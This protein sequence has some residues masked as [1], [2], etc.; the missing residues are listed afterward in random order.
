MTIPSLL[1]EPR[2]CSHKDKEGK[3][4]SSDSLGGWI[5]T[6][7]SQSWSWHSAPTDTPLSA[8]PASRGVYGTVVANK[9][10]GEVFWGFLER[11]LI[12]N[13]R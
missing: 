5:L 9:R 2:F 8:S 7:K 1:T 10:K 11:I 6:D 3:V 12:P 4:G 13:K